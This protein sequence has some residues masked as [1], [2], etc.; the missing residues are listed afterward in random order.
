MITE[1]WKPQSNHRDTIK[2]KKIETPKKKKEK[3]RK[4]KLAGPA[5]I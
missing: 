2:N 3:K 4:K 1:C 5:E